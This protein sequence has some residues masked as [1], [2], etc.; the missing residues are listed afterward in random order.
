[1]VTLS[2][3][4]AEYL[5]LTEARREV[6]W[7]QRLLEGARAPPYIP[8]MFSDSSNAITLANNPQF[9]RRS[10]HLEIRYRWIS[11]RP[12][13]GQLKLAYVQSKDMIADGLTKA[14]KRELFNRFVSMLRIE[15]AVEKGCPKNKVSG[16]IDE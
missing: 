16:G 4:E 14:L 1:M 3:T 10:R 11:E 15:V 7:I 12:L 5:N 9:V 13:K 6:L 2:T 8:T